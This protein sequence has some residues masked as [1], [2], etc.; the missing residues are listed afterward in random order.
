MKRR[1]P[2]QFMLW[3]AVGASGL[4]FLFL[5]STYVVRRNNVNG[6]NAQP[7]PSLFWFS[8]LAI[9][10]SSITLSRANKAFKTEHFLVFRAMMGST[11]GLGIA[12]ILLQILGWNQLF[13]G[14]ITLSKSVSGA[15]V[16]IISGVHL[17]HILGGLVFLVIVFV[18]ALKNIKYVDSFV[19]SVNP[20]N[21]LKLNLVSIYWHFVDVLWLILFGFMLMY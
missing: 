15:F 5:M 20:P 17:L 3:L 7:L 1:E 9:L 18:E 6:W 10:L 12:F 13:S 16:F 4:I 21:Q 11:L 8:T 14:G 2:L 19:Y